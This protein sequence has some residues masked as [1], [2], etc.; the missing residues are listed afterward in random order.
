[1][2]PLG[3]AAEDLELALDVLAGPDEAD[4]AAW[5]LELPPPR[6]QSLGEYRVAVWLDDPACPIDSTVGAV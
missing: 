5:R 4:D 6:G 2:G 1:M 3:R